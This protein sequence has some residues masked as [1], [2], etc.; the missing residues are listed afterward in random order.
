MVVDSSAIVAAITGEPDSRTYRDALLRAGSLTM[1]AVA[2]LETRL[3][4]FARLGPEGPALFE[5]MLA[6]AR[7]E[8]IAFDAAQA[9]Y[10]F[11]AFRRFGKGQGHPAQLNVI[12][13][14]VYA[15]A[16]SRNEPLLFKGTDFALTDLI[17][18]LS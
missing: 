16:R 9:E 13:C 4:L 5:R 3:V 1:S 10:A 6:D 2:V 15:L 11:S 17:S 12:D 8:I 7:I 14:A 18:A